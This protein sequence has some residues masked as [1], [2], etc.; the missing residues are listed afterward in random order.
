LLFHA[1]AMLPGDVA[2]GFKT[3]EHDDVIPVRVP[4]CGCSLRLEEKQARKD[5]GEIVLHLA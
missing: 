4:H 2:R 5:K 1:E 3:I